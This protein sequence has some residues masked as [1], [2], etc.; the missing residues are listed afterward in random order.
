MKLLLKQIFFSIVVFTIYL[1]PQVK[2]SEKGDG[3]WTQINPIRLNQIIWLNDTLYA[4]RNP[5]YQ[6]NGGIYRSID[7]GINWD[8]LFSTS[9]YLSGGGLRLFIHP[10]NHNILYMIY[11]SLYRSTNS[12]QTWQTI[13]SS[14]GSLVRLGINAQNP[15]VMYV[16]KSIPYGGVFKT[17]DAG[18]NWYDASNGLPSEEY[19]QSG[20]IEVNPEY[21]DTI[22]LGTNSGLYRSTNGGMYWDTTIVNGLI[23]GLNIHPNLPNIAFAGTTYDWATYKTTDFGITWYKT[24]GSFGSSKYIFNLLN[25]SFIYNSENLKSTN[26]GETWNKLDTIFSGWGDLAINNVK[27]P[28]IYGLNI[29]YGL[30]EYTDIISSIEKNININQIPISICFP[31][32][33]N[34]ST[35]IKF[36]LKQNSILTIHIY[37]SLGQ[38]VK[39]LVNNTEFSVGEHQYVWN[40]QDD[41]QSNVASGFYLCSIFIE[42]NEQKEV[43]TIKLLLLK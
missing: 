38:K 40:G 19:F 14:F 15:N 35:T 23:A 3:F 21:P 43:Q 36:E 11:G 30:F 27:N 20:P 7:E 37:N 29:T 31:N 41:Y 2:N 28:S 26:C 4:S 34:N 22:L 13:F 5:L 42:D 8:T 12:G 18:F 32:P 9:E 17:T 1:Q 25:N 33:F 24:Q 16:T 6:S 10:T 39:T